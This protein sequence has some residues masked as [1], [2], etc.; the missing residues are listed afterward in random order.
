M[1]SWLLCIAL[2]ALSACATSSPTGRPGADS[3]GSENDGQMLAPHLP[4][5]ATASG[6]GAD[7]K[8]HKDY[9]ELYVAFR[10]QLHSV[11]L[12][13]AQAFLKK[14]PQSGLVAYVENLRGLSY[15]AKRELPAAIAAFRRAIEWGKRFGPRMDGFVQYIRYN[16]A[17]AYFSEKRFDEAENSLNLIRADWVDRPNQIKIGY[18]KA[19]VARERRMPERA[20]RALLS[21]AAA[22]TPEQS[23]NTKNPLRVLLS[24]SLMDIESSVELSRIA[25]EN[26]ESPLRDA[27]L[28]RLAEVQRATGDAASAGAYIQELISRYPQSPLLGFAKDLAGG[29]QLTDSRPES[30]TTI[31][32][33]LPL[34]GKLAP[35]GKRS[36]NAILQGFELF[37]APPS[38][39][40]SPIR[41]I[42]EDSGEE[43]AD[44]LA[45]LERLVK[46]A[47]VSAVLGPMT[48]K[49]LTEVSNRAQDLGVPLISLTRYEAPKN[50]VVVQAGITIR[51]QAQEAARLAMDRLKAKRFAILYPKDPAGI[52]TMN[53]F[54]DAVI[55]EGGVIAGVEAYE[56]GETDFRAA[57]DRLAGTYYKEARQKE[58]DEMEKVREELQIK[59]RTR[60]TES[61]FALK[62]IVDF[63]AVFIADGPQASGQIIPTFAFRDIDQMRFVGTSLWNSQDLLRRITNEGNRIFFPDVLTAQ[64]IPESYA[65]FAATYRET[66]GEDPTMLEAIAYDAARA[67]SLVV[68]TLSS[69][70][71]RGDVLEG[72]RSLRQFPGALGPL[73]YGENGF[74]RTFR[75]VTIQKGQFSPLE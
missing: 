31:G 13:R 67:T 26:A 32:V 64:A 58:L 36:L 33:L 2:I 17:A 4:M 70:A 71:T 52:E 59:K 60:K 62:P 73:S 66:F 23:N 34:S 30:P 16:L 24:S 39:A 12:T 51:M 1:K 47:G 55:D 69:S 22:L 53:A 44:A 48:G 3:D 5:P 56:S 49:G 65:R 11:A 7:A 29:S 9:Q 68:R 35:Y 15:L 75:L 74:Q 40:P 37:G 19:K 72:L 20:A 10:K 54:W 50:S 27:V 45:A 8:E 38:N 61:Y 63:D 25:D 46:N 6:T 21:A 43:A 41:V 14:Y 57:I 28:Y 42:V 18:L